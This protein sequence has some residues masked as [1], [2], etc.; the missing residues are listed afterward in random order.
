MEKFLK[1][2]KKKLIIYR[3]VYILA[4]VT[5]F[6]GM[7]LEELGILSAAEGLSRFP[8]FSL[9]MGVAGAMIGNAV[10]TKKTLKDEEKQKKKYI[11][12]TDER[13]LLIGKLSAH[14]SFL[15]TLVLLLVG[16]FVFA[17]VDAT[18]FRTLMGVLSVELVTMIFWDIYYRK[19]Y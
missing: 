14:M 17:F 1:A 10:A 11:A 9:C 12:E 3:I 19:K 18:V 6:A 13:L 5:G 16:A 2:Q 8:I 4:F 7:L 15:T